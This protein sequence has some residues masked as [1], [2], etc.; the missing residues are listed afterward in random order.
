MD[1]SFDLFLHDEGF[2]SAFGC[3]PVSEETFN[4][5][6]GKLPDKLLE[7]WREFGFCGC[8]EGR[9]WM[10]DPAAFEDVVEAWLEDT[11]L[12]GSDHYH[13]FARTAFGELFLWGEK[14]GQTLRYPPII[15]I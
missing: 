13:V 11:P 4:K 9:L 1:E 2:A 7:Y 6:R 3:R 14:G 10:V 12:A 15:A 5:Y 8:G